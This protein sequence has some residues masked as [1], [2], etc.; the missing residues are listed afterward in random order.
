MDLGSCFMAFIH[1]FVMGILTLPALCF[2]QPSLRND[3][4]HCDIQH[5][6]VVLL[7]LTVTDTVAYQPCR[8][9][10]S[11]GYL[12]HSNADVYS[13]KKKYNDHQGGSAVYS[14]TVSS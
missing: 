5:P 8:Y 2:D 11:V 3:R 9:A 6:Y 14:L 4:I 7:I 13:G 1:N 12:C 10:V